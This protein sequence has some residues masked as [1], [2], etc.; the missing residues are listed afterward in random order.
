MES[1]SGLV[2]GMGGVLRTA[3][4]GDNIEEIPLT[5]LGTYENVLG[6]GLDLHL[7]QLEG[8]TADR[9]GVANGMSG[10]PVYVEGELI[11]ALSYRLGSL[12]RDPVAGV[13]P[14]DDI[15]NASR[16]GSSSAP[17][18]D[19]VT[20]PIGTP[21]QLGG[22]SGPARE[23]TEPKLRELGLVPV[24]GGQTGGSIASPSTL[25]AGS[26]VGVEL[27]RGDLGIAA[28][29]T[30]TLVDGDRVY[31]FGHS[32]LGEGRMEL[33]M[34]SV[35]VLHTLA[36][37]AGSLRLAS[38]G[39]EVGMFDEDRLSAIVGR[40]GSRARMLPVDIRISGADYG[41]QNFHYEIARH[42]L[43]SPILTAA[44]VANSLTSN[45]GFDEETTML[46]SG[47]VSLAGIDDLPL[48]MAFT[49]AGAKPAG[50][51]VAQA[52]HERLSQLWSN[53]FSFPEV[54]ALELDV[55][56]V[57]G[58]RSY[59]LDGLR[60]DRGP[61]RSGQKLDVHCVLRGYRGGTRTEKLTLE[62]PSTLP[63]RT[64]LTLAVGPPAQIERA[65]GR[66]IGR[67]LESAGDL[68]SM[69]RALGEIHSARRLTAVLIR[70][71]GGAVAHGRAFE[72]LP[73]TAEHLLA[74][75]SLAGSSGRVSLSTL[76]RAEIELD[77]PVDG[78]LAVHLL[79]D[80]ALEPEEE[81]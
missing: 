21:V 52:L 64:V 1:P 56:V 62:V 27:V 5:F 28:T 31:A 4:Q 71:A 74:T 66:P 78:G 23:W 61:L 49:G 35:G 18:A 36:D 10:S 58:L 25:E 47:R 46:A 44:V 30:V 2:P 45:L 65:L 75:D 63:E 69:V 40:T 53:P 51:A 15:L 29:G 9:I 80:S 70:R 24:A 33:P 3:L 57:A 48:E 77:G 8:P 34:I 81:E 41:E 20:S 50:L 59:R 55:D 16:R 12:P 60:Y 19:R 79:V 43:L 14:I 13:T 42:R 54:E 26:P 37:L 6:P 72:Q 67:R 38:L 22:M 7:V 32:F 11:G 73:P 39:P 76:A 17:E 68:G